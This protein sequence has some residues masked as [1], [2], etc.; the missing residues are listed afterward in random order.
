MKTI[1][2]KIINNEIKS[3]KICENKLFISILDRYPISIGHTL[4]IVKK[5]IDNIIDLNDDLYI[6]LYLFAKK[7]SIILYNAISCK[8]IG[9][10]A[11]GL[12]IPHVHIHL[13][14]INN[15]NDFNFNKKKIIM[16]DNQLNIIL[17][18]IKQYL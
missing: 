4:V 13:I 12:D 2:S 16:N 1:F 11:I 8:K 15:I 17:K 9:I 3:F 6:K 10:A 14:P 5:E 7:I 18:S